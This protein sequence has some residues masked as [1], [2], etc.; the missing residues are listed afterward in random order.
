M[1]IY[2]LDCIYTLARLKCVVQLYYILEYGLTEAQ[3]VRNDWQYSREGV[4]GL[5]Y[6]GWV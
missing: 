5:L 4:K 3:L 2:I 6:D 1:Y